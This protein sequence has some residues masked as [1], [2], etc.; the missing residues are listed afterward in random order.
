[1]LLLQ[2]IP[3][4]RLRSQDSAKT[5]NFSG[6]ITAL[7][8]K[9]SAILTFGGPGV[10]YTAKKM[11]LSARFLPSLRYAFDKD[12]LKPND[13]MRPVLGLGFQVRYKKLL[14]T[15]P[16]FYFIQNRW[17]LAAGVGV[18]LGRK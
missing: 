14:A 10:S 13:S 5:F 8:G 7:F 12:F 17:E 2:L 1:M 18:S 9:E 11:E 3:L 16:T 15:L 4:T 6:Q